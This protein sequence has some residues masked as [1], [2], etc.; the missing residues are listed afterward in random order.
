MSQLSNLEILS[1]SDNQIVA[2]PEWTGSLPR[3]KELYADHNLLKE[4]PNRL[5]VASELAMISVCFNRLLFHS[6]YCSFYKISAL[7]LYIK[8]IVNL[9]N[10]YMHIHIK[11]KEYRFFF[12]LKFCTNICTG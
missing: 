12:F 9:H 4:L 2:L 1:V 11:I 6:R 8:I 5:T 3:L 10:L 7:S